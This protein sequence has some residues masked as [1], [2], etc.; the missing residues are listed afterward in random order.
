MAVKDCSG[1]F[2]L[3]ALVRAVQQLAQALDRA[4]GQLPQCSLDHFRN[5]RPAA[6]I[7]AATGQPVPMAGAFHHEASSIFDEWWRRTSP[8]DSPELAF[9]VESRNRILKAGNFDAYAIASESRTGGDDAFEVTSRDYE[10]VYY[11]GGERRDLLAAMRDAASWCDRELTAIEAQL[12]N[13][14]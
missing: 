5:A 8:K 4:R 13:L 10:M 3:D 12:P 14:S 1:G 9:I 6:R 11:R 2:K 7:G